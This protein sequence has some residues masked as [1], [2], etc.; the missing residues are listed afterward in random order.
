MQVDI[1]EEVASSGGVLI[2]MRS[3]IVEAKKG[4]FFFLGGGVT[5]TIMNMFSKKGLDR[6]TKAFL[7]TDVQRM[8]TKS[9]EKLILP[10]IFP[11]VFSHNG[12]KQMN[13]HC[14]TPIKLRT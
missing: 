14:Q 13:T 7:L 8:G 3:S 11:I 10:I 1:A 12:A 5:S 9:T 2:R 4:G 6:L